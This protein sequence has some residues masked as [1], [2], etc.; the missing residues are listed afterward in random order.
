ML[1]ISN[2]TMLLTELKRCERVSEKIFVNQGKHIQY[3]VITNT[4]IHDIYLLKEL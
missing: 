4:K 1:Q 2:R 3:T